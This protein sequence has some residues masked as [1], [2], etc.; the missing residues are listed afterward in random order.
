MLVRSTSY[1]SLFEAVTLKNSYSSKT[2]L[3]MQFNSSISIKS[4]AR[5][6]I[7]FIFSLSIFTAC[8]QSWEI[9]N[10][11]EDVDWSTFTQH[12]AAL[13]VHTLQSDGWHMPEEVI[14]AYK[15]AGFS[16]LAISDHDW[17][18]PNIRVRQR[19]VPPENASP[20][21]KDPKPYNFPANTTWP[22]TD[23][24]GPNPEDIGMIGIQANE[25]TFRHH[26]NSF[27][28]N[29]GVWYERTGSEAPY[30][31][32]TDEQ[33]NEIWEDD[34]LY[35]IKEKGGLAILNHPGIL[36]EHTWWQRKPVDWYV[37]RF[38]NHSPDYLVGIEVTNS[39]EERE[40]YDEG[41]WDQLLARFMP[42]RPIWGFGTDDMHKLDD[43]GDTYSV[44]I[45]DEHTEEAV[46]D[47]MLRG[48]FYFTK[49]TRRIDLRED[50]V[51]I[52]PTIT[53]IQVNE[54]RG[55]IT[56]SAS[57]YDKILWISAPESLETLEDFKTSNQPWELGRVVYEG[58]TL[59]LKN[60]AN[61]NNY[62]RAELIRYEG[63]IVY[64]T[65][66]NPFG[67]SLR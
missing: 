24:G 19:V 41:L 47:A 15:N 49:S 4:I 22:W 40:K 2:L 32:I 20:Y 39:R 11:Y 63:D 43:V 51:S 56:I 60:T 58:E 66:T 14:N 29:Y 64:R 52:F 13:H 36:D 62:V 23:F 18:H 50:K 53:D 34:Q 21:P 54:P 61:I 31:G 37:E 30:G 9:Q 45:I 55:S 8:S 35:A 3:I 42:E 65:F 25:L 67:I 16:I 44:F 10:P 59:D 17:N 48:Q 38:R 1:E 12:K 7:Y 28:S 6:L 46:R 26:I 5:T 27:F 33:G 57:D